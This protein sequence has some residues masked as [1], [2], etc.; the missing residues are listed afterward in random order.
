MSDTFSPEK[1]SEVMRQV[2]SKRN[3]STE[4]RLVKYFKENG[5]KGWRR[6]Y[7]LLGHPDFVFLKHRIALFADGCFWHGHDCRNTRPKQNQ[8][9]WTAKREKNIKRD[10]EVN[11]RLSAKGWTVI[12]LWECEIRTGAFEEKLPGALSIH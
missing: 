8:A 3:K 7:K 12:R 9:Y 6:N 5:I 2:K 4:L 10:Q 11:E 1:R